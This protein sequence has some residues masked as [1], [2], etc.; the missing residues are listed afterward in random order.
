MDHD[1][2]YELVYT[3]TQD[4]LRDASGGDN[5][6]LSRRM[7]GGVVAFRDREGRTLKEQDAGSFFKKV[8]SVRDKLRVLEQKLNAHQSLSLGEKAELQGYI[9]RAYGSLT[10]FNSLFRDDEDRFKGTGG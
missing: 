5:I 10:T 7:I 6:R 3:A 1:E 8:T 2:L 4:A 9:T